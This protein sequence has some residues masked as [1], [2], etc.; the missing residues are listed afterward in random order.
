MAKEC[1]CQQADIVILP[2]C[3]G[4][5][6]G[7]LANAAA[8]RMTHEGKGRMFCLAGIGG[9]VSSMIA[10]CMGADSVLVIDGCDV[11]CAK[12]TV[13]HAGISVSKHVVITEL[14][15]RRNK[16]FNIDNNEIQRVIDACMGGV[17]R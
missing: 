13:E 1:I 15:I 9:H 8:V 4:S 11:A 5:N 2:C 16:N 12:K 3:G 6:L 17:M 7:Q 14:G 10:S